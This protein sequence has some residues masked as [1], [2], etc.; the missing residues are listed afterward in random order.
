MTH[1]RTQPPNAT[2]MWALDIALAM[3]GLAVFSP[4]ILLAMLAVWWQDGYSPFYIAKRVGQGERLFDMVKL[5][6]MVKHA[7]QTGVASTSAND[8]RITAVGH[9]IRRYKLDEITQL[10]NVL[11]GDMSLV[12]PRPNVP[13]GV[14]LYT[15][16]ERELLSV[17]PGITDLASIVFS[18]EGEILKGAANADLLYEQIIRPWKSRLGLFYVQNRTLRMN[19]ELVALTA[20]AVLNKAAALRGVNRI[21]VAGGADP[22]LIRVSERRS[23]LYAHP[24]PGASEIVQHC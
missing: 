16:V 10:W 24:P 1:P 18:D 19:V 2:L 17:R 12:G 8:D 20:L 5:R 3:F 6:S 23:A 4:I 21:L 13:Q 22:E 11:K 7:D 14:A 15:D 9:T